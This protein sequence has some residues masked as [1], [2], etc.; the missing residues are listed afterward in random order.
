M[1]VNL[2]LYIKKGGVILVMT[3]IYSA[4]RYTEVLTSSSSRDHSCWEF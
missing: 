3:T 2:Y 1:K 4:P